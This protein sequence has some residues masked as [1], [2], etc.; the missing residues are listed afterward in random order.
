[1][2]ARRFSTLVAVLILAFAAGLLLARLIARPAPVPVTE[3]AT[4]IQPP[5]ELPAFALVDADG[6]PFTNA[7]LAGG[8]TLVFFGF[9]RCPDVCP[10]TLATLAR[11]LRELDDLPEAQRPRVLLVT[12]DPERDTPEVLGPYVRHFDPAFLAAT[13]EAGQVQ[14]FATAFGVP[15]AKVSVGGDDYTMDHGS[16][17]FLVDPQGRQRAYMSAPHEA[18][19]IARDFR[20]VAGLPRG[21]G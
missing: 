17:L 15:Y 16:G 8:W 13:G 21:R 2:N 5:R 1:M 20:A 7:S 19:V 18:S 4:V 6:Q 10:T 14:A 9:A 11:T 3:H 12:V